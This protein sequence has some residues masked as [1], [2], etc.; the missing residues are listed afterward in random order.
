VGDGPDFEARW[1]SGLGGDRPSRDGGAAKNAQLIHDLNKSAGCC[2]YELCKLH[3]LG[4]PELDRLLHLNNVA[5]LFLEDDAD[6]GG[7]ER[8]REA[9]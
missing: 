6:F 7:G 3:G 9:W 4:S 2:A 1:T 5:D 8:L